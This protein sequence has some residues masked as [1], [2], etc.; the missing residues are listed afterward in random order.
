MDPVAALLSAGLV[1]SVSLP[2]SSRYAGV[3]SA[4]YTPAVPPGGQPVPITYLRR[5]FV[6][7]PDRL[8]TSHEITCVQGDRRDNVA[9]V[10]F[11]DPLLWW[12]LADA[13]GVIDPTNL[14]APP[15]RVLRVALEQGVPGG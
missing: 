3:G 2:A 12:R 7:R 14:T 15:G 10:A 4:V 6:P 13:N 8:A 9:A 5:R 1:P 11:G